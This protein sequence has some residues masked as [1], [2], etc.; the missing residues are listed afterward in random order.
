MGIFAK[1]FLSTKKP[2]GLYESPG[3]TIGNW[4]SDMK[5]LSTPNALQAKIAATDTELLLITAMKLD[6]M[7]L[8]EPHHR[9]TAAEVNEELARRFPETA[10]ALAVWSQDYDTELSMF[11]V[12]LANLDEMPVAA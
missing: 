11:Q 6:A 3:G 7:E 12:I 10:P 8:T 9:M 5:S 1:L 2:P 4:E